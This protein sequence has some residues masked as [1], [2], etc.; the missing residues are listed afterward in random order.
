VYSV[1]VRFGALLKRLQIYDKRG[2]GGIS[3]INVVQIIESWM[4]GTGYDC[5]NSLKSDKDPGMDER[6]IDPGIATGETQEPSDVLKGN[7]TDWSI[8]GR[9]SEGL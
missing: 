3:V 8:P 9:P 6:C 7:V 1:A 4:H 2:V 5:K